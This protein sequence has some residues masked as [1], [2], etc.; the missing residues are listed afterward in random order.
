MV[1][2]RSHLPNCTHMCHCATLLGAWPESAN[3]NLTTVF[4]MAYARPTG[5]AR[6]G[7][8]LALV[9]ARSGEE[10]SRDRTGGHRGS[11]PPVGTPRWRA[12]AVPAD[13]GVR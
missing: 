10:S 8:P 13:G 3:L 7:K 2:N 1:Y 5:R 4:S 6:D 12:L 9:R 11:Q